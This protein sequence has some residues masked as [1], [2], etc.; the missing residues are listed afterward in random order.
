M[1]A[2]I[3]ILLNFIRINVIILMN[4]VTTVAFNEQ[5]L[6]FHLKNHSHL[7]SITVLK[8]YYLL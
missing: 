2:Y 8:D 1:L 7:N 4:C 5:R 6:Q 3:R